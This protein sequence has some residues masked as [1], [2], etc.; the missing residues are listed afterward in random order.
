MQLQVKKRK[1][2]IDKIGDLILLVITICALYIIIFN[3]A[4][5]IVTIIF[6]MACSYAYFKLIKGEDISCG[7]CFVN[8]F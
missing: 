3:N 1:N 6:I 4:D 2:V 5:L 7:N 8:S